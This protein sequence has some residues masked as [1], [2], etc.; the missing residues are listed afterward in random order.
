MH[1]NGMRVYCISQLQ[2]ANKKTKKKRKILFE[3]CNNIDVVDILHNTQIN[4]QF[5]ITLQGSR[6]ASCRLPATP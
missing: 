1:L 3:Q 5:K 4:V 2:G 6:M